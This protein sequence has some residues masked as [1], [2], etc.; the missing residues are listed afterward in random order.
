MAQRVVYRQF[1]FE[2]PHRVRRTPEASAAVWRAR[3]PRALMMAGCWAV[4]TLS[5]LIS[6][7]ATATVTILTGAACLLNL[8]VC[9]KAL[10]LVRRGD[11]HT[12]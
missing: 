6:D 4:A 10:I 1:R 7:G 3:L 11:R 8:A 9:V 2:R 5:W 12:A